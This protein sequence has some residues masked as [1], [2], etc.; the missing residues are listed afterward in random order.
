MKLHDVKATAKHAAGFTLIEVLAALVIVSLGMLGVIEA[1]N[2]TVN[3]TAYLRDKSIAHW[4]AMNQLTQ[5]RLSTTTPGTDTTSDTVDMAGQQWRWTMTVSSTDVASML[6]V[7]VSVR[8]ADAD[9]K[10]NLATI[11]GFYGTAVAAP[12]STR[13]SWDI[14]PA[15]RNRQQPGTPGATPGTSTPGTTPGA[16]TPE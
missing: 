12:G 3:N 2:Q 13:I 8:R 6:R 9:E 4:V 7:D 16:R 14:N 10:S 11:S 15:A 1:V 5:T